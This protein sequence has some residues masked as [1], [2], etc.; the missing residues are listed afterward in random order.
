MKLWGGRF[1][2]EMDALLET[3]NASIGFDWRLY[4]ADIRGSIAYARALGRLGLLTGAEV[5]TLVEG[6]AQVKEEF[7]A[8]AFAYQPADEDIHTAVER[9]LYELKGEVAGKLHT[10][11]SRNDQVATDV[12][13]YLMARIPVLREH[14]RGLQAAIVEVASEHLDVL[15]PGYT[16]LQPAQ[17]ILFSHWLMAFFWMLER[18][19]DRLSDLADRVSVMPLGSAALAGHTFGLDRD[20]LASEL[21]FNRV[22]EN[23]LDG[24]ADRDF[25]AETLF[26]AAL[27]QTHLSRMAEDLI[28]YASSEFGFVE[29]DDAFSTGSSIMPQKKNPDALE[30]ARGK[31][32]RLVGNLV[33]LLTTLKG[34]PSAYD[35]DL[36]EDKE[37]LFDTL[38]T[39]EV[40]LP[41]LAGVIE[42]LEV[43]KERMA[44][45]LQ[46]ELLA[47]DLADYLVRKGI[48]FRES[49]H[50]IGRVV[51][52][53]AE[54]DC[55]LRSLP[56]EVYREISPKFE[57]DIYELL[58][59][60]ASVSARDVV[61]GTARSSV[62]RQLE[63]AR[64]ILS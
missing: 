43:R 49:H 10:G 8:G 40:E 12:R 22:S 6:L 38:D 60:E 16:H 59:F 50:Q 5:S 18:D 52:A 36:Q 57:A 39:L 44:A 26:W 61:G 62:E 27:L 45:A 37:P 4:E 21:G 63:R 56:L 42:T 25:V 2:K 29:L 15:M 31:T 30:L 46:D 32:G 7:D 28:I 13:L 20:A 19:V 51:R 23:S 47:T 48:P 35:K 3:F 24:V 64:A 11:R 34:I 33:G 54:R 58:D 14:L 53:A 17:P 1:E 9:R 55:G 41:V